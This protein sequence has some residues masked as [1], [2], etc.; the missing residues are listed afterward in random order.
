M[1]RTL[2]TLAVSALA[3]GATGLTAT[4][5]P[6]RVPDDVPRNTTVTPHDPKP[7]NY[8]N[9]DP[10]YEVRPVQAPTVSSTPDDNGVEVLQA[11]ASAVG[12]AAIAFSAIWLYRRRQVPAT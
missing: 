8:P 12:G 11:G 2:T 3:L 7:P 1:N 5:A 6:A 9:Y 10:R 4:E